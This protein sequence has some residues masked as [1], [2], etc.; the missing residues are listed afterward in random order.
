[1]TEKN[2]ENKTA[3]LYQGELK[4]YNS[5]EKYKMHIDILQYIKE[6]G[7]TISQANELLTDVIKALPSYA[8]LISVADYEKIVGRDAFSNLDSKNVNI[9]GNVI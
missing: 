6:K 3:A 2:M 5:D 1:M 8:I 7:L 9:T 4:N